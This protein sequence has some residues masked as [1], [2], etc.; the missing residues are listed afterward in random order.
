MTKQIRDI[1]ENLRLYHLRLSDRFHLLADETEQTEKIQIL[2]KYLGS[3]EEHQAELLGK[4]INLSSFDNV[5]DS[6]I[7]E[8]PMEPQFD[9]DSAPEQAL[10][11]TRHDVFSLLR[12]CVDQHK[13]IEQVY[14]QLVE[15][16]PSESAKE[17]FTSLQL[18]ENQV[19]KNKIGTI[20]EFEMT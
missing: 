20:L 4:Q 7:K 15:I 10:P 14:E 12:A 5:L 3:C 16:K 17:Y 6:W 19:L 1:L 18:H 9:P 11:E 8:Q 2:L 13:S